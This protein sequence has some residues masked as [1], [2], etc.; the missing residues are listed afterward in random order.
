[1]KWILILLIASPVAFAQHF[2]QRVFPKYCDGSDMFNNLGRLMYQFTFSSDCSSA[3]N[4][5]TVNNGKFCDDEK[6][7]RENGQV[8]HVTGY[9][10]MTET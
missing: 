6:L 9:S 5:S 10:A 8:V 4:Q 3:L 2:P 1:M 7:V